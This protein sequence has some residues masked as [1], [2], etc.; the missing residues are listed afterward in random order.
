MP[1]F[2]PCTIYRSC[3][4]GNY[5]NTPYWELEGLG[6]LESSHVDGA[7]VGGALADTQCKDCCVYCP[8]EGA[9][10][11]R[12][13]ITLETLPL[14]ED[15]WRATEVA[16][17]LYSCTLTN[18]CRGVSSA[19]YELGNVSLCRNGHKGAA[20]REFQYLASRQ[21][22]VACQRFGR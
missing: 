17:K 4:Q 9:T 13:G 12:E 7:A 14:K 19:A 22:L 2:E 18:A 3:T 15:W 1:R 5:W 21:E 11:S 16:T 6:L 10:C 8:E 20:Q